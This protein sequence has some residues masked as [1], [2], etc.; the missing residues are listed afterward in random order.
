MEL[1]ECQAAVAAANVWDGTGTFLLSEGCCILGYP[2]GLECL[3]PTAGAN[4][5]LGRGGSEVGLQ[6]PRESDNRAEA[7]AG[8]W[9]GASLPTRWW[10]CIYLVITG[11]LPVCIAHVKAFAP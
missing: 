5:S 4:A 11:I 9:R 6:I 7:A 3:V 2:R 8:L 10:V 1:R